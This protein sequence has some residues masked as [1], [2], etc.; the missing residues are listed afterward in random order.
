M[1]FSI[2]LS[3]N[4]SEIRTFYSVLSK[5]SL[6]YQCQKSFTPCGNGLIP[7]LDLQKREWPVTLA[8]CVF[9]RFFAC[10]FGPLAVFHTDNVEGEQ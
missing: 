7:V 4:H 5:P 1:H 6:L 2:C 8:I 3:T 10:F 9:S